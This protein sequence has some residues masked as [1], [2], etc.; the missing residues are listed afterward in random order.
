M[1]AGEEFDKAGYTD[2]KISGHATPGQV[3]QA[4]NFS[5]TRIYYSGH[6]VPFYQPVAALQ[7][8]NRTIHHMD[9]ATGHHT[10]TSNY[11]TKGPFMSNFHQGNTTVQYKKLPP[12]ST[13]NPITHRPNH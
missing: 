5:F 4:G 9:I 2:L 7:L 11:Y 10:P 12:N 3:K 6:E 1:I 8:F 13:Y